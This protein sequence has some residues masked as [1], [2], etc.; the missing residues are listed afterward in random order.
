MPTIAWCAMADGS[1]EFWNQ[2]WYDYTGLSPEVARGWQ[3][4]IHP[5]HLERITETWLAVFAHN[6]PL[7]PFATIPVR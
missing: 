2:R 3:K 7:R 4:A 6:T 5:G 1:G